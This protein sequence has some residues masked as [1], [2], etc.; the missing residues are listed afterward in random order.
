M[1]VNLTDQQRDVV[2][3]AGDFLLLACPG[4]GK[5]RTAAA[6]IARLDEQ[7]SRIAACSYTN[8]GA[9]RIGAMLSRDHRRFFGPRSF[10]GTL[11][12][13]LLTYVVYPFAHLLGAEKA[14]RLWL[15]DWPDFGHCADPR[16]R[17]SLDQFRIAPD[18][19]LL[20]SAPPQWAIRKADAVLAVERRRVI[21]GKRGLFRSQGVLSADDA[22]WAALRILREVPLVAAALGGASTP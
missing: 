19:T 21:K 8:V 20:F 14:P 11:H 18:G 4:S 12:G 17:L 2:A 1:A 5:T 7:G 6:R 10:N 9:D 15:G 3:R 22:M 16:L 13:F